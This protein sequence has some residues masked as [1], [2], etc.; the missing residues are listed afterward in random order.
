MHLPPD[1]C[2]RTVQPS[3]IAEPALPQHLLP[4]Q[5]PADREARPRGF[6]LARLVYGPRVLGS[7]L[8]ALCVA[9]AL[10]QHGA[11]T[12]LWL[13]LVLHG[14]V[15]P[16]LAYQWTRRSATPQ[17][18]EHRN[19]LIDAFGGGFWVP[20]MGFNLIPSVLILTMLSLDNMAVG[21]RR[22][23]LWG[24]LAHGV[25]ALLA[26]LVID[27]R[28][29]LVSTL[30]TLV[31][32]VPFLVVYPLLI[33]AVTYRLSCQLRQQREQ[34]RTLLETDALSGLYSRMHWDRRLAEEFQR[35]QRHRRPVTLILMDVDHFKAINDRHGHVTGDDA[36]RQLG[37]LLL[38]QVRDG[39]I[40]GR[41]GGE[42]FG[43]ILPD[44]DTQAAVQI[45]E[46][47][48][49]TLAA[50]PLPVGEGLRL[51]MSF[52]VATLASDVASGTAWIEQADRVL[53]QAKREGRNAVRVHARP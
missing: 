5:A 43:V 21:G 15:W 45:A 11:L 20:A 9:A 48:R 12:D 3:Q 30:T 19:L 42:E 46:R 14:F 18:A 22:V 13:L 53:Y 49:S 8:A 2:H 25:G 36:I 26:L 40:A 27:P 24:L 37:R 39:D 34:L 52:G 29:E 51:S 32:C 31:A 50:A 17:A 16:H 28:V 33:G 38:Q 47:I 1:P 7:G 35:F 6:G 10:H 23:F 4:D 41:Y 44:T